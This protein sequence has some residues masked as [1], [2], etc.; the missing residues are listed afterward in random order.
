MNIFNYAKL[1]FKIRI[2]KKF[3]NIQEANTDCDIQ[4]AIAGKVHGRRR[5]IYAP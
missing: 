1:K 5:K 4:Y 3:S 2:D